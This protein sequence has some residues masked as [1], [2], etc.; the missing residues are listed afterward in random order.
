[1]PGGGLAVWRGG[2]QEHRG[3]HQ[4]LRVG[5][6][7]GSAELLHGFARSGTQRE[8]QRSNAGRGL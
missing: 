8:E 5:G 1:M 2:R 6:M 7:L 4:T 3:F